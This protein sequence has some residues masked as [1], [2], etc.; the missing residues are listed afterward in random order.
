M[1]FDWDSVAARVD[2]RVLERL[3]GT[4]L[5]TRRQRGRYTPKP[6]TTQHRGDFHIEREGA[7]KAVK[8]ESK[9]SL[10]TGSAT[11]DRMTEFVV[12]AKGPFRPEAGDVIQ[13]DGVNFETVSVEVVEPAG[14]PVVY[15]L[16][17]K[18]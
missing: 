12:S 14:V 3:G 13:F 2:S 7:F 10:E 15:I 8:S 4:A 18:I 17:A 6:G 5:I 11:T 1:A 16:K 9:E